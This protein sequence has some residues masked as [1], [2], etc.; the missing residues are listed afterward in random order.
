MVPLTLAAFVNW[1]IEETGKLP[2]GSGPL[3][4]CGAVKLT[5]GD[6]FRKMLDAQ[7]LEYAARLDARLNVIDALRIAFETG[8]LVGLR[9]LRASGLGRQFFTDT[10]DPLH[11]TFFAQLM[12]RILG[13]AEFEEFYGISA[14]VVCEAYLETKDRP[15]LSEHYRKLL[16]GIAGKT[17][18][19]AVLTY[20][21]TRLPVWDGNNKALYYVNTPDG[22]CA[23]RLLGWTDGRIPMVGSGSLCY[24]EDKYGLRREYYVKPHP[25]HALATVM[26]TLCSDPLDA[27]EMARA[28]CESDPHGGKCPAA[29]FLPP[30]TRIRLAV[31]EDSVTGIECTKNA[32]EVLRSWGFETEVLACGIRTTAE[33]NERLIRAGAILYGDVNEAFD[34]VLGDPERNY[35]CENHFCS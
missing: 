3:P 23:L 9:A 25:F 20:R 7:V 22:E 16:P 13:S 8:R 27:L 4:D 21:P 31:F 34:K 11:C 32:A 17:V 33:K 26:R 5:D 1:Y 18:Y 15:L 10:L 2:D 14:P 12:C 30:E 29:A 19:P 6:A 28:L 24:M 35:L